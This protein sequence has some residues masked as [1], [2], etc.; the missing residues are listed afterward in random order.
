MYISS[1]Y[2]HSNLSWR[3][4]LKLVG[5]KVPVFREAVGSRWEK[6]GGQTTM[7]E[8]ILR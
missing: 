2:S 3:K 1:N 5:T 8:Q 7:N 4:Y 6:V